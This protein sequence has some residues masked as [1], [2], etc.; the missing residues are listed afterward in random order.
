M[1]FKYVKVSLKFE[2][3]GLLDTGTYFQEKFLVSFVILSNLVG[4]NNSDRVVVYDGMS[5][6]RK[7]TF[8]SI[9]VICE[10]DV[11]V[12]NGGFLFEI[13]P[14]SFGWKKLNVNNFA[15]ITEIFWNLLFAVIIG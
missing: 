8:F 7:E 2:G 9:F 6:L 14:S 12:I 4:S 3:V 15:K 11:A 1:K 5:L 13:F 10:S